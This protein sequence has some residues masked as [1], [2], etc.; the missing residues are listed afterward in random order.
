MP[1]LFL[2]FAPAAPEMLLMLGSTYLLLGPPSTRLPY[3]YI[4]LTC[5]LIL[6]LQDR[7]I[8]LNVIEECLDPTASTTTFSGMF[9]VD[10]F[11]KIQKIT[12]CVWTLLYMLVT[13]KDKKFGGDELFAIA[14]IIVGSM[15]ALSAKDFTLLFLGYEFVSFG[16]IIFLKSVAKEI[17]TKVFIIFGIGTALILFGASI[18]Y[19]VFRSMDF[20]ILASK[21]LEVGAQPLIHFAIILLLLG[22][23]AKTLYVPFHGLC[24]ETAEKTEIATF[25]FVIFVKNLLTFSVMAR[26]LTLFHCET[27][28]YALFISGFCGMALGFFGAIRQNQI[29]SI[30]A[31]HL[32]GTMG[33]LQFGF[34][35]LH[36][37]VVSS[38]LIML[39]ASGLSLLIILGGILLLERKGRKIVTVSNLHLVRG[40]SSLGTFLLG[41]GA[42]SLVN[43]IPSP[44]FVHFFNF[45]MNFVNEGAFGLLVLM[46]FLKLI[47]MAVGLKFVQALISNQEEFS[48]SKTII[49][50]TTSIGICLA[51]VMWIIYSDNVASIFTLAE[52]TLRCFPG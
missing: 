41:F 28:R 46:S 17:L 47:S 3:F 38:C 31:C 2:I 23:F 39:F 33:M 30:L 44:N 29:K 1:E 7:N 10:C 43:M 52:A 14:T 12:I 40:T 32:I 34:A 13:S 5:V 16:A 26:F 8:G 37:S 48:H 18:F 21:F 25:M 6:L 4:L 45:S 15:L 51:L 22:L 35:A 19:T 20:F 9:V 50:P 42:L 27:V 24:M 11:I 36:I 49:F